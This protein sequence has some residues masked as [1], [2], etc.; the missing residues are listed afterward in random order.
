MRVTDFQA[1]EAESP[2]PRSGYEVNIPLDYLEKSLARYIE[3]YQLDLNPD[4]Q[5]AHVWTKDQQAAYVVYLLQGGPSG[6][7]LYFACKGWMGSIQ[8]VG[9]MVIVDGKQ[10]LEA[11]RAFLR[12]DLRVHGK[13]IDK[14]TGRLRFTG[15]F[16]F[17]IADCD[18]A[19]T[20]R[21]YL[22]LNSG[23][24]PHTWN[25]LTRVRSLLA[26]ERRRSE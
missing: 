20:L 24:T 16:L 17:N 25:E 12:G 11:V 15:G 6:R 14:W 23:G 13:F 26:K 2:F 18:R 21:W 1:L 5:R 10:R 9:P 19:Q 4:F 3:E 8:N 22:A 7:V